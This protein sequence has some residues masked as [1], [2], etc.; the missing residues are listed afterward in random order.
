VVFLFAGPVLL[1]AIQISEPSLTVAG[2]IILFL[3]ALRMVFPSSKSVDV[4]VDG[5]RS[6]SLWQFLLLLGHPQWRRC[7]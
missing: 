3:I 4:V 7:S 2:G 5:E 6:L 1:R